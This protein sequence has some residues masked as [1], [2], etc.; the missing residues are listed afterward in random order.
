MFSIS[1]LVAGWFGVLVIIG[2]GCMIAFGVAL[3]RRAKTTPNPA[4]T[5]GRNNNK[6]IVIAIFK[7]YGTQV[8]ITILISVVTA[9]ALVLTG[10]VAKYTSFTQLYPSSAYAMSLVMYVI[11]AFITARVVS[12]RGWLKDADPTQIVSGILLIQ[13]VLLA[14]LTILLHVPYEQYGPLIQAGVLYYFLKR[15]KVAQ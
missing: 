9:V 1:T 12:S 7:V 14:L 6:Q 8:V 5:T 10:T 3:H 2:I 4:P 15:L 13:I 11:N